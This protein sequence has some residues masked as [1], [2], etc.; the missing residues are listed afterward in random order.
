VQEVPATITALSGNITLSIN[1]ILHL[2]EGDILNLDYDPNAPLKV[3]VEDKVK[4][5]AIPGTHNGKKAI[6]LT[7]VYQ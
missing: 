2:C 4:F 1:Q 5:L 6:S 3:L 7:G